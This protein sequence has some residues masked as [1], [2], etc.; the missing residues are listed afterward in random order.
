MVTVFVLKQNPSLP[1]KNPQKSLI[2]KKK[3]KF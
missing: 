3:K 1:E 2:K